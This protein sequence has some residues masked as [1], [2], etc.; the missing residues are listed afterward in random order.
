MTLAACRARVVGESLLAAFFFPGAFAFLADALPFAFF[1][2]C[3][4]LCFFFAVAAGFF[5]AFFF[6]FG[7]FL[8]TFFAAFLATFF[9][10]RV[11]PP[12]VFSVRMALRLP[13]IGYAAGPVPSRRAA[14]RP[15]RTAHFAFG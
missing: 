13:R 1:A 7:F 11:F 3:F 10:A 14:L 5:F 12:R 8:A 6:S 4:F 9:F 15:A 2:A